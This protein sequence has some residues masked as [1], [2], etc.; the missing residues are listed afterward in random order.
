[1]GTIKMSRRDMNATDRAIGVGLFNGN[2]DSH[3]RRAFP[4]SLHLEFY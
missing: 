2:V 4:S 1:M 3:G